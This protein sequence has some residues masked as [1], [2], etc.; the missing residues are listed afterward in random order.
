[1]ASRSL[2]WLISIVALTASVV[3]A[4][5]GGG[6]PPAAEPPFTVGTTWTYRY[7]GSVPG[8]EVQIG[9]VTGVYGVTA[10]QGRT[11]HYID[12]SY[13]LMPDLVERI[14][15]EWTGR[16]FRHVGR[17][18]ADSQR[19]TVE[20][21][22]DR[23]IDPALRAEGTGTAL[24]SED[25]VQRSRLPVRYTVMPR[26]M[27]SISVPVGSFRA[28]RWDMTLNVDQL[29]LM[30]SVYTVGNTDVREDTQSFRS[31]MKTGMYSRELA[32]GPVR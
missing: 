29:N 5:P 17:V 18:T 22:F 1:M 25:G 27:T 30:I 11:L 32:G 28:L 19:R 2:P 8:G 21:V 6:A 15:F 16:R 24:V 3:I 10:S 31:G 9:K 7:T 13:D 12:L 4:A 20:T 23:A 14:Y 26:G